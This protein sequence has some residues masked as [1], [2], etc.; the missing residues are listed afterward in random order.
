MNFQSL[1]VLYDLRWLRL[2][3]PVSTICPKVYSLALVRVK[4]ADKH[5]LL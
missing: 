3:R 2:S 5:R 4:T 1:S